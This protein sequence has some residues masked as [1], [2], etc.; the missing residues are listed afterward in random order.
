[1]GWKVNNNDNMYIT[2]WRLVLEVQRLGVKQASSPASLQQK[3]AE[4]DSRG[5]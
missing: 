3:A 4:Q 5:A 2:L 1:M